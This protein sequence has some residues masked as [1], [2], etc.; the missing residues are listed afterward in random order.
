MCSG[1]GGE[2][3]THLLMATAVAA[4]LLAATSSTR[5]QT[6]NW[7]G[8]ISSDWFNPGNWTNGVPV[9]APGASA[10]IDTET[11]FQGTRVAFPGTASG[12]LTIGVSGKGF[13]TIANGGTVSSVVGSVG[14]LPDSLGDVLV[15]GAGSTWTSNGGL[16]VGSFGTGELSIVSGG[17][18]SSS[19]FLAIGNPARPRS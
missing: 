16:I 12:L 4:A 14:S 13:L 18:L 10:N 11:P 2:M 8:T 19:G 15:T 9:G 7:T 1:R 17:T 5:A 3:R 6:T